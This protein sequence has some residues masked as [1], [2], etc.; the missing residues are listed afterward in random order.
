VLAETTPTVVAI[1][2]QFLVD[3]LAPFGEQYHALSGGAETPM[4]GWLA[5]TQADTPAQAAAQLAQTLGADRAAGRTTWGLHR[6]DLELSLAGMPVRHYGSQGQRKTFLLALKL[7]QYDYLAARTTQTPILLLDDVCDRLDT[8]RIA[9]LFAQL[10]RQVPG[11]VVVTDTSAPRIAEALG[12]SAF[13]DP[14]IISVG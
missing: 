2:R 8:T 10:G 14:K 11:Q 4:L 1:R 7:A 3:F 13:T 6:E 12:P 9:A 5:P